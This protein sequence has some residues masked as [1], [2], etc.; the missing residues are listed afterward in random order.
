MKFYKVVI[1]WALL[2]SNSS[3][4]EPNIYELIRRI[5]S[6]QWS[7]ARQYLADHPDLNL[8]TALPGYQGSVLFVALNPEFRLDFEADSQGQPTLPKI[9]EAQWTSEQQD[10]IRYLIQR[11]P[12]LLNLSQAHPQVNFPLFQLFMIY[13]LLAG[14]QGDTAR[15]IYQK[16]IDFLIGLGAQPNG[17][18]V[19]PFELKETGSMVLHL[20]HAGYVYS[21]DYLAQ[22]GLLDTRQVYQIQ[23]AGRTTRLTLFQALTEFLVLYANQISD[24]NYAEW[25]KLLERLYGHSMPT[26]N[27]DYVELLFSVLVRS[28]SPLDSGYSVEVHRRVLDLLKVLVRLGFDL[29]ASVNGQEMPGLPLATALDV[30]NL[31]LADALIAMGARADLIP[32]R[33]YRQSQLAAALSKRNGARLNQLLENRAERAA[34]VNSRLM[35]G[36]FQHGPRPLNIA[37]WS[38]LYDGDLEKTQAWI[39]ELVALGADPFIPSDRGLTVYQEPMYAIEILPRFNL[40]PNIIAH[41][42]PKFYALSNYLNGP[43]FAKFVTIHK[44]KRTGEEFAICDDNL[45]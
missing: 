18:I 17:N 13:E 42:R 15:V 23:M 10:F 30:W 27:N 21:L 1:A 45:K 2:F 43:E 39:R 14:Q 25:L 34:F 26:L 4:A 29:N 41:V 36:R 3:W 16:R 40:D 22:K 44:G 33:Q 20:I 38:L 7:S 12:S 24:S 31:D 9:T 28:A 37:V 19:N 8:E 35:G 6:H 5:Q 11:K 32:P